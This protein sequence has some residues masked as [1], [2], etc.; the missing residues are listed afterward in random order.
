MLTMAS[1]P[2]RTRNSDRATR[3]ELNEAETKPLGSSQFHLQNFYMLGSF[4]PDLHEGHKMQA[5]GA[6]IRDSDGDRISLTALGMV[7]EGCGQ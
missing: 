6:L 1:E 5:K 4:D 7:A 3:E 2:V